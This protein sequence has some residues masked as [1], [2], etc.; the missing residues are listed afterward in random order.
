MKTPI[1]KETYWDY[2]IDDLFTQIKDGSSQLDTK[3]A[4]Q[5][6]NV[7]EMNPLTSNRSGNSAD[8]LDFNNS[9]KLES[10]LQGK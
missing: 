5:K 6:G 7:F 8:S 10:A 3:Y 9:Q 4:T 2:E 1:S